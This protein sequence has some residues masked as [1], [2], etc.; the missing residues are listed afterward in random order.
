MN[1]I[2]NIDDSSCK[3]DF[4]ERE[5]YYISI[6]KKRYDN[7]YKKSKDYMIRFEKKLLSSSSTSYKLTSKEIN[8]ISEIIEKCQED[9]SRMVLIEPR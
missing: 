2:S 8:M 4:N 9:I 5:G 1:H 6:T 3:I 7:A